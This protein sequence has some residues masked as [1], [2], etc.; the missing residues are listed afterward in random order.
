MRAYLTVIL[1]S[2]HE[3]F[4]S[5]VLYILLLVMTVVLAGLAPLGYNEQR[6]L[7][8]HRRDIREWPT[9]I[10]EL[11]RQAAANAASPGKRVVEFA[12]DPLARIIKESPAGSEVTSGEVNDI[13]N[14]LNSLLAKKDL[15]DEN[16]WR[17][18][19]LRDT[20]QKL[21]KQG[22]ANLSQDDLAYFNRLLLR[23]AFPANLG[24]IGDKELY[25][26]YA[27]WTIPEPLPGGK[28]WFPQVVK[29]SLAAFMDLFVGSIA[30][31]VAILVTAAIIPRTFEAGAIDLLLSK[32]ISRSLLIIAKYLGGCAFILLSAGYFITGLW[33]IIG[34]RL[35]VWSEKLLLCIPIFMFQFA[36]YYAVSM[37]AGV[38]WRNPIVSIVITVLFFL[39]CFTVGTAKIAIEQAYINPN[40]LV[41]LVATKDGI[42]GATRTGEFVQWNDDQRS[43][44]EVLQSSDDR[45]RRPPGPGIPVRIVGPV[46]HRATQSL[47]Y[48]K[49]SPPIPGRRFT[50]S[51]SQF[52][53]ARWSGNWNAQRGPTPPPGAAWLL[54]DGQANILLVGATGVFAYEPAEGEPRP[55]P[56]ILGFEIALGAADDPFIRVGPPEDASFSAPYSA[57]IDPHSNRLL[58]DNQQSLML[59][60]RKDQTAGYI[61]QQ[62]VDH[63][64]DGP[65]LV[66]L[67]KNLVVVASKT[68]QVQFRSLSSLQVENSFRPA[69]DSPPLSVET[70]VD[71][72]YV[73]VLFHN[74]VLWLYDDQ[75]HQ[76]KVV[77]RRASAITF[78][79]GNLVYADSLRQVRVRDLQAGNTSKV[80]SPKLDTL[81]W[82]YHWLIQPIYF[83]FPKPGELNNLIGTL[84]IEDSPGISPVDGA[85]DLRDVRDKPNTTGP[86]VHGAIFV[87]LMLGI[88]CAYVERLDL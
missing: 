5:R 11:R 60:T 33:L 84:L 64:A 74:G 9:F 13:V 39:S 48:L 68:G 16:A 66:G 61:V 62:A 36:I 30:I 6:M 1:D 86:V 49:Q 27:W 10:K 14:G 58:I 67:T 41:R 72:R 77:D 73:A 56:K 21:L 3:A 44:D 55:K 35:D 59:L 46:Y 20:T 8:F 43:W 4:A 25:V 22:P 31:F 78:D 70:S 71:G 88:T 42:V 87:L 52:M 18:V 37:L 38:I 82:Y 23:D 7:Q 24:S 85:E 34:L 17:G 26:T 47:L 40:Q 53:I 83:V 54:Q 76:G 69:G 19:R 2:F 63:D 45:G 75:A 28:K 65:R 32:P 81:R 12:G 51:G 57:A 50:A 29:A 15:Y 80:Y 79:Q